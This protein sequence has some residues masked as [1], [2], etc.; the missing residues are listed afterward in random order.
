MQAASKRAK[1]IVQSH[2]RPSEAALP[3]GA[4][5]PSLRLNSEDLEAGL[6]FNSRT[7]TVKPKRTNTPNYL[8]TKSKPQSPSSPDSYVSFK[9]SPDKR[10][11]VSSASSNASSNRA[12]S[13]SQTN[14]KAV[15]NPIIGG[16]S[17]ANI[18][19]QSPPAEPNGTAL[20]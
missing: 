1:V 9:E 19:R 14:S 16:I 12:D 6:M 11:I 20:L 4:A 7:G 3:Y 17:M 2:W 15:T 10:V 5:D 18:S 8:T 13:R